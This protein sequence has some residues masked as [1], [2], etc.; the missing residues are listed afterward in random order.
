[1]SKII[2]FKGIPSGDYESFCW[3]VTREDFIKIKGRA[4]EV[5]EESDFNKG[6]YQI[7]PDEFYDYNKEGMC[8][9]T[10]KVKY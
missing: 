1:M 5:F 10:I 6:L 7:Y 2:E 4:P 8:T 3:D 9:T